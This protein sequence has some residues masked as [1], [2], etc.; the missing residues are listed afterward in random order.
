MYSGPSPIQKS[1]EGDALLITPKKIVKKK[2]AGYWG[3]KGAL[4]IH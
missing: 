1:F 2:D 3:M 4:Q